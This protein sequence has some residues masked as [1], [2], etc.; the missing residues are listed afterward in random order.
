MR[1]ATNGLNYLLCIVKYVLQFNPIASL[2][3]CYCWYRKLNKQCV[4]DSIRVLGA[5]FY[6]LIIND[7]W[8]QLFLLLLEKNYT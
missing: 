4:S 5:F 6:N 1:S 3:E 2:K 8:F 7:Q